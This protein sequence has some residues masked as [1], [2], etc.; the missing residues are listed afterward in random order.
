MR[1]VVSMPSRARRTTRWAGG[2]VGALAALSLSAC[3]TVPTSG[4]VREGGDLRLDR[5][6][7]AV[8]FI[9]NPPQEG[10]SAQ[11]VVLGFLR[12][13]ADFRNDHRVAR[14]HLAPQV[15][16]RWRTGASTTIYERVETPLAVEEDGETV[17]VSGA[18]VARIDAEG[19]YRRTPTGT[20][21]TRS[22]T[23]A[24]VDGEWR[25]AS[26]EDG[27]LLSLVDA[28]ESLRQ[29]S[30]YFLSPSLN[31]LVP[32]TVLLPELPGLSTRLVSRLLRGPTAALRGAVTT[33][34]PQGTGLEVPSVPIRDGLVTVRL[35]ETALSA[36]D[37]AR[38]QMAAQI[39][40]TVKQLGSEV[41]SVRITAGGED[42]VA[43][44]VAEE[45]PR[46]S[47]L[48]FDPNGLTDTPSVYVVRGAQVGRIIEGGFDPVAGPAG[49]GQVAVRSPAVSLD[50]ARLAAVSTDGVALYV[51]RLAPEAPFEQVATGGDLG[52]PSWDPLG[53]L[54]FV[55]RSTGAVS[56][57]PNGSSQAVPVEVGELPGGGRPT[58]L[59][60]SRDGTRMVLVTRA[61][62]AA[63]LL[64]A[65]V[66]G[67]DQLDAEEPESA[68]VSIE[69][70]Q[71][72]LPDL[73]GVR[74]VAWAD[75]GTLAVLGSRGGAP[76]EP[77]YTSTDGYDV[78]EVQAEADLVALA[79]APPVGTQVSPLVAATAEGELQQFTSGRAWVRLG[80]GSGPAY[81]G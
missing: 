79:A 69:S 3:A 51:G 35:D 32:D 11:N 60:L 81:P 23:L 20:D 37:D 52:P 25:I 26:L 72:V 70:A 55:D 1:P 45:Q 10:A 40:W 67:V 63:R 12:A 8:P 57:I 34:F 6:N 16:Q 50:E 62:R 19:S 38:E 4:P 77:L 71:E 61:G 13:S 30:L 33:A 5:E 73:R 80:E 22:F 46:D 76:V 53:N 74:D 54:W 24:R 39:V 59:A 28:Q 75:A 48:T 43:S 21:V 47:W 9:A 49:G 18:E 41:E 44:G 2:V 15:R 17:T 7:V 56:V 42:L 14:L 64:V 27:L 66:A 36:G 58:Q 78:E 31:T 65:T 68:R 29:V